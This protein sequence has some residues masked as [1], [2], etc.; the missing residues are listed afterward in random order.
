MRGIIVIPHRLCP[1]SI[2]SE[3]YS[4]TVHAFLYLQS[5]HSGTNLCQGRAFENKSPT[6]RVKIT[7]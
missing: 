2:N 6:V 1:V 4:F 7:K 5:H 3:Q